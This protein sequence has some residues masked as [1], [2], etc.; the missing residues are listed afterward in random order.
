MKRPYLKSIMRNMFLHTGRLPGTF[1]GMV[2]MLYLPDFIRRQVDRRKGNVL[3]GAFLFL[4][5]FQHGTFK[6][7]A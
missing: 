1:S 4:A 5:T 3:V 2:F 6:A 7:Y